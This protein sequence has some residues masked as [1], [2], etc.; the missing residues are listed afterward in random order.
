M[1]GSLLSFA[2]PEEEPHVEQLLWR[3]D[4]LMNRIPCVLHTANIPQPRSLVIAVTSNRTLADLK[5]ALEMWIQTVHWPAMQCFS[6]IELFSLSELQSSTGRHVQG[7]LPPMPKKCKERAVCINTVFQSLFTLARV[8]SSILVWL[9]PEAMPLRDHWLEHLECEA[10]LSSGAWM[11]GS[12]LLM[13]CSLPWYPPSACCSGTDSPQMVRDLSETALY[14]ATND[15][16]AYYVG[17]WSKS[18]LAN[19]PFSKGLSVLLWSSY[20][21]S[22]Q[23]S[24]YRR[25]V[26]SDLI[27]NFGD[28]V[29]SA[30]DALLLEQRAVILQTH[31]RSWLR[32]DGHDQFWRIH[33]DGHWRLQPSIGTLR[34]AHDDVAKAPVTR[35]RHDESNAFSLRSDVS[36]PL[37]ARS[38]HYVQK[39]SEHAQFN[40]PELVIAARRQV[41]TLGQLVVTFA[42]PTV[43]ITLNQLLW[44]E[45]LQLS[46]WLLVT[47]DDE[48]HSK[49]CRDTGSACARAPP[50]SIL[51][52]SSVVIWEGL[53]SFTSSEASHSRSSRRLM[54]VLALVEEGMHIFA[55]DADSLVVRNPWVKISADYS[56]FARRCVGPPAN[57]PAYCEAG[58][59]QSPQE[60]E[61][62][63]VNIKNMQLH[64][65]QQASSS[66]QY[67]TCMD[68]IISHG[69]PC[70]VRAWKTVRHNYTNP[71]TS[72]HYSRPNT[73][74]LLF[75]EHMKEPHKP[76]SINNTSEQPCMLS[77]RALAARGHSRSAIA[78]LRGLLRSFIVS[79]AGEL[80]A[81]NDADSE[82]SRGRSAAD[83]S[84]PKGIVEHIGMSVIEHL[85]VGQG[86]GLRWHEMH[87]KT[88]SS[89][90]EL[91]SQSRIEQST[92]RQPEAAPFAGT[93]TIISTHEGANAETSA[94]LL[95]EI[96]AW[97]LAPADS[98]K[99]KTIVTG[100][101]GYDVHAEDCPLGRQLG[102]LRSA[103]IMAESLHRTLILP[104]FC[105]FA[106]GS[107][108]RMPMNT[109]F[110]YRAFASVFPEHI[111]STAPLRM[112]SGR[113]TFHISLMESAKPNGN[114]TAAF[115]ARTAK[116]T[117]EHQLRSWMNKYDTQPLIWFDRTRHRI[118]RF[119][120]MRA[121]RIFE[122]KL[123][124][125]VRPAPE[126]WKVIARIVAHLSS[127]SGRAQYNCLQLSD[128]DVAKNGEKVFRR[129][130]QVMPAHESTLLADTSLS[131]S[132]RMHMRAHFSNAV[133]LT[134]HLFLDDLQLLEDNAGRTTLAYTL[135]ETHICAAANFFAG[136]MLT[137]YAQ[138]V[139]Y[140]RLGKH[141]L[142]DAINTI[143]SIGAYCTDIYGRESTI[144]K[145]LRVGR[146]WI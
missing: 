62:L 123:R 110:D 87:P 92:S 108:P 130:A 6:K 55:V 24:I 74:A 30:Q 54:T 135:V 140:E 61:P 35:I 85:A 17:E 29:I 28:Q 42:W 84:T 5:Q 52:K 136:N 132:G 78:F 40:D 47:L 96:G 105:M 10:R 11:I 39:R 12:T 46:N 81:T 128:V 14:M 38:R 129:A 63:D 117:S 53:Q 27:L 124:V 66:A 102:A 137:P 120:D 86:G 100:L 9:A 15:E 79:Q 72:R 3:L 50:A 69:H 99:K 125:G 77:I 116:G 25:F 13:D 103:L 23:R 49:L 58:K 82:R 144:F 1:F 143:P 59:L 101:M 43:A 131:T 73:E 37:L 106:D 7:E 111:E 98:S 19:V 67:E 93:V 45:Q 126:L 95:R 112:Q 18:T 142:P 31:N 119:D 75:A 94:F 115:S 109:L 104:R 57:D 80:D 33:H 122:N 8:R 88:L 34:K 141:N 121:Q 134:D 48:T 26:A 145:S 138:T 44:F 68:I 113:M 114:F 36:Q 21:E 83:P 22:R 71:T 65:E 20:H 2:L 107:G 32:S 127:F 41:N 64:N 51:N 56:C 118:K 146:D 89:V 60:L 91:L 76:L 70:A 4:R 133:F 16:L 90:S 139:C 97:L